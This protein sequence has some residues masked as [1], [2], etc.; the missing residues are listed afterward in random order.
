MELVYYKCPD[1]GFVYQVP[2]YWMDFAPEEILDMPH[3]HLQTKLMCNETRLE[4]VKEGA[5][6]NE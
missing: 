2:E 1:C 4:R 6:S 3:I 5:R